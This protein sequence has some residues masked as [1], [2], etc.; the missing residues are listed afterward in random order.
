M[1]R[2]LL[3]KIL[4]LLEETYPENCKVSKLVKRLGLNSSDKEFSKV[5]AYLASTSKI[6]RKSHEELIRL[7]PTYPNDEISITS[8][9]IDFLN[10][11]N[12]IETREKLNRWIVTATIVIAISTLANL[13]LFALK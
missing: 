4:E 7:T 2:K 3:I 11:S 8:D 5:I 1:N 12:L 6:Q 10:E 13:I 9:G